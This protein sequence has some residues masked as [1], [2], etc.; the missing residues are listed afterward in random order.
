MT[1]FYRSLKLESVP[2]ITI[3]FNSI[4]GKKFIDNDQ[5]KSEDRNIPGLI[6]TRVIKLYPHPCDTFDILD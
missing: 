6:S 1:S 2:T 5:S 3:F 4:S